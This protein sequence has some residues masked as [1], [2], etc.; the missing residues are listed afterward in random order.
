MNR[1]D[2]IRT[3]GPG[4]LT[5][6]RVRE[7]ALRRLAEIPHRIAWEIP[8]ATTRDNHASLERFR[9]IHRGGR[10]FVVANGPSLQRT[11]LSR[12]TGEITLGMN[13]IYRLGTFMPTY[14]TVIDVDI[15][16]QQ[17]GHELR[18][19]TVPKF[20]NW[21]ARR[22]VGDVTNKAF[23][24]MTFRPR[25]STNLH[26]GIWGGHSVTFACLQLAYW[27]GLKEVIL[28]GK[29]HSYGRQG[30]P[31]DVVVANTADADHAV[32]GYYAE[33]QK[34]RI[35]DYKGEELAYR[36]ALE[37]FSSAGRRVVDATIDGKLNVFPKVAYDN[38]F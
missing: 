15:Q 24:K 32:R 16:L 9:D 36:A 34:F 35:P 8:S 31:G 19:I 28:I 27:M 14:L 6:N 4:E 29:D 38:L 17:M 33:G 22:L 20:L 5:W 3:I 13:R 21:N 37:A 25:F 30:V 12:L 18:D 11:D 2:Y 23:L 7:A 1:L 26:R 10:G